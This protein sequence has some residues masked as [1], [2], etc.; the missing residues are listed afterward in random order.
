MSLQF[1]ASNVLFSDDC[2]LL[3]TVPIVRGIDIGQPQ[4]RGYSSVPGNVRNPCCRDLPLILAFP[5][6]VKS[7]VSALV[8]RN[9]ETGSTVK[10]SAC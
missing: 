4:I 3:V 9:K 8:K 1:F 10:T 6:S 5:G 7:L 2:L